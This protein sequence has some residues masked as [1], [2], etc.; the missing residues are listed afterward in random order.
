[1]I[2]KYTNWALCAEIAIFVKTYLG[3]R[4]YTYRFI[5]LYS[6]LYNIFCYSFVKRTVKWSVG[7]INNV[8]ATL[9]VHYFLRKILCI[10]RH[11][12]KLEIRLSGLF[13]YLT[14]AVPLTQRVRIRSPIGSISWLR[15]FRVFFLNC[16][17]KSSSSSS[18]ERSAQGQVLHCKPMSQGYNS[19]QRQ[20]FHRKLRNQGCNFTRDELK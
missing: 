13:R 15:L 6:C 1:M 17:K 11:H 14:T 16:K 10:S 2:F 9:R 12:H 3:I 20:V 5:F 8:W 18:S 19:G 7:P 4:L